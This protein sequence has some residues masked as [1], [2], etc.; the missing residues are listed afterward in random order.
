MDDPKMKLII[1]VKKKILL[2]HSKIEVANMVLAAVATQP[3]GKEH[4][5]RL[6]K[7]L[8]EIGININAKN[9]H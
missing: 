4:R 7:K 8:G 9:D 1:K 5:D 3:M 6:L 2:L